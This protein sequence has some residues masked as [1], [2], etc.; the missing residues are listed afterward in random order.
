VTGFL[1]TKDFDPGAVGRTPHGA[2]PGFPQS[3]PDNMP[4]DLK[5]SRCCRP[6]K[7][8][9]MVSTQYHAKHQGLFKIKNR[10]VMPVKP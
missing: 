5:F 3:W 9:G 2:R 7:P 10:R 1:V 8:A 4:S 6:G